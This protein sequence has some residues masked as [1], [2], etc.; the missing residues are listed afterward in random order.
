MSKEPRPLLQIGSSKD[1]QLELLVAEE[2]LDIL[3]RAVNS[4]AERG[5]D[6]IVRIG[7]E[8]LMQGSI[9][10]FTVM[11]GSDNPPCPPFKP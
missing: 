7:L 10:S 11:A 9:K 4:K 8:E 2:F 1:G 5:A 6:G 3:R